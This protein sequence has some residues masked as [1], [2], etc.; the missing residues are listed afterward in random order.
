MTQPRTILR[1]SRGFV[2]VLASLL[3]LAVIFA[4]ALTLTTIIFFSKQS[5]VNLVKSQKAYALAEAGVEDVVWRL[6]QG[7]NLP[8]SYSFPLEG[9]EINVSIS[10]GIGGTKVITSQGEDDGVVRRIEVIESLEGDSIQ[11]FFGAQ[12]GDGGMTMGN[13]SEIDGNLFSNATVSGGG[14]ITG[15]LVVAGNGNKIEGITIDLDARAHTCKDATIGGILYHV[16]GTLGGTPGNC[17]VGGDVRELPNQIDPIPLPISEATIDKWRNQAE[18]AEVYTGDYLVTGTELLGPLKIEG[19]LTVENN[20]I[21]TIRGIIWVTGNVLTNNNS[22]LQLDPSIYGSA[23][24][25][26]ITG[27]ADGTGGIIDLNNNCLIR[28]TGQP[29]SY[30]MLLTTS[31]ADPAMNVR[32]NS[33]SGIFYASQGFIHLKN[34]AIVKEITGYGVRLDNN[35]GVQYELGLANSFFI[36]GPSGGWQVAS[37]R[38][39]E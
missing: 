27:M 16:S 35:V 22:I 4:F 20:A 14:R 19:N 1:D 36:Q 37:W 12:V 32:N 13:G 2:A 5:Y 15:S 6:R 11:F 33:D 17:V 7:M 23:S 25:V 8:S 24:G 39:I 10:D 28:G 9:G 31:T 21:L 3:V 38:E 26:L 18:T 34:N 30:L 29:G